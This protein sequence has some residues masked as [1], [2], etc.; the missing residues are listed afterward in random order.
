MKFLIPG[1]VLLAFINLA[2]VFKPSQ[3]EE[4]LT[5]PDHAFAIVELFTSQGCSSCPPADLVL[6]ELR[7]KGIEQGLAIY[8]LSFHVDYWNNLGWEDPFSHEDFTKRQKDYV[9]AFGLRSAYTPQMVINGEIDVVGS[10]RDDVNAYVDT[11]LSAGTSMYVEVNRSPKNKNMYYFDT[12]AKANGK[13]LQVAV[14][15]SGIKT[16]VPKGENAGKMLKN[17]AVVVH[18]ETVEITSDIGGTFLLDLPFTFD[19]EVHELIVYIQDK[20]SYQILAA[21][22]L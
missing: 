17:D 13:W 16:R 7:K 15:E 20:D 3:P 2:L 22:R 6:A 4:V 12:P 18:F 21:D 9:E 5:P 14:T 8:T 1:I 10:K 11:F 19:P